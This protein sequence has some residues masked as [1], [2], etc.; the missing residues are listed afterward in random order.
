MTAPATCIDPHTPH[1][2]RGRE[3]ALSRLPASWPGRRGGLWA[4][5]EKADEEMEADA[6]S[7]LEG[8]AGGTPYLAWGQRAALEALPEP[9][10]TSWGSGPVDCGK[11]LCGQRCVSR[12][13][14]SPLPLSPSHLHAIPTYH[15]HSRSWQLGRLQWGSRSSPPGSGAGLTSPGL[16]QV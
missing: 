4:L 12:P 2:L 7:R 1:L 11:A 8:G 5:E 9:L 15:P 16:P 14:F 3:S 6:G 10:P 13:A